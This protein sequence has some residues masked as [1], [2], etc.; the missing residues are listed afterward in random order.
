MIVVILCSFTEGKTTTMCILFVLW[1]A[2]VLFCFLYIF[3]LWNVLIALSQLR[4]WVDILQPTMKRAEPGLIMSNPAEPRLVHLPPPP[5]SDS[6]GGGCCVAAHSASC[7]RCWGMTE[8]E[9]SAAVCDTAAGS[10][11]AAAPR[12]RHEG[13]AGRQRSSAAHSAGR[14]VRRCSAIPRQTAAR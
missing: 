14:R 1:L 12:W 9:G 3:C 11:L 13:D 8:V 4:H 6:T 7:W 5:S 10:W 2:F